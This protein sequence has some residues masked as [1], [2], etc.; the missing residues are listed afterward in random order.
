MSIDLIEDK[1]RNTTSGVNGKDTLRGCIF[2]T[3]LVFSSEHRL[4][5]DS[6]QG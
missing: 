4:V 5:S 1:D 6:S 3:F 2:L